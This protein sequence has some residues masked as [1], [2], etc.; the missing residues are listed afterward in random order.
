MKDSQMRKSPIRL[1]F[2]TPRMPYFSNLL[3]E[4]TLIVKEESVGRCS[5]AIRI[6]VTELALEPI[7][8]WT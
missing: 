5:L 7:Q 3:Y 4:Y 2:I 6:L 8:N 1:V